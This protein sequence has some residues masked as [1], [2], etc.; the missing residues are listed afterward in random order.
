MSSLASMICRW[1]Y[2]VTAP[3]H[4]LGGSLPTSKP[5]APNEHCHHTLRSV[6]PGEVQGGCTVL[7][8]SQCEACDTAGDSRGRGGT[9]L[10]ISHNA[11]FVA[12]PIPVLVDRTLVVLF[13][14]LG[15]TNGQFRAAVF[16]VQL[17]RDQRVALTLD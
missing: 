10:A 14:A 15:K 12:L 11:R 16:P 4:A 6:R 13:L 17:E 3:R 1:I 9:V 8:S 5:V 7:W 2:E